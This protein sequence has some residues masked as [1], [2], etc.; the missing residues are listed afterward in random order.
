VRNVWWE[1]DLVTVQAS[2]LGLPTVPELFRGVVGSE[3]ELEELTVALASEPSAFGG[4]REGVVVRL[5][6]EFTDDQFAE[7]LAK[8][9]RSDHVTTD[10]HW[11]HQ[12]I[13]PQRLRPPPA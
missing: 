2:D 10:E 13:R 6:G 4:A 5:A 9:V 12:A 1:W 7:S 3:R 11:M 8:W